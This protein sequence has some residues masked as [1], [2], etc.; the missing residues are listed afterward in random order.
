MTRPRLSRRHLLALGTASLLALTG[1]ARASV[2][3]RAGTPDP[4]ERLPRTLSVL[5]RG[6]TENLHVGAQLYVS[7][8]GEALADFGLGEA[9]PGVPMDARSMM[10][11]FS[12]TKPVTAMA[13]AHLWEEGRL[14]L[15]DPIARH[16]PAFGQ[17][18]KDR[19]TIRQALSHTAGFPRADG[20]YGLGGLRKEVIDLICAAPLEEGWIPGRFGR[21]HPS[22]AGN[23]LGAMMETMT[24]ETYTDY[25]RR[26]IF[27][28]L[29]MTDSW[30]GMSPERFEAYG[31]RIGIM[32]SW[33]EA[34][35]LVPADGG[36]VWSQVPVPHAGGRGP[37]SELG[38]FYEMLMYR[39]TL[40]GRQLFRPQTVEAMVNYDVQVP[41]YG[42][43]ATTIP[44]P[45]GMGFI[46][47]GRS[48]ETS[49]YGR[50]ASVRTYGHGGSLSSLGYCDEW[51]RLCV[52]IVTNGRPT[53][54]LH[55]RRFAEINTALYEDLGL[56]KAG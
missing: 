53:P 6:M 43:P 34:Q 15:D 24:G 42:D 20:Q 55:Y 39:G 33:N 21:Y 3:F 7:R 4:A 54:E 17:N 56:A 32:H 8:E 22:A 36:E 27:E 50:H 12:A 19:V 29:G 2:S 18:G 30:I 23:I 40:G 14:D 25:T 51:N 46:Q 37:M 41:T 45:T 49:I 47:N 44:T 11:W 38:R 1:R 10:I 16:F 28:P 9:R 13:L 35:E 48:G 26:V 52:A 5:Q 31:D